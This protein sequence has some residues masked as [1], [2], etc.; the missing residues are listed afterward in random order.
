MREEIPEL[1]GLQ[2]DKSVGKQNGFQLASGSS[3]MKKIPNGHKFSFAI[4]VFFFR[5]FFLQGRNPDIHVF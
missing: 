5:P 4:F 1:I 2:S 3:E